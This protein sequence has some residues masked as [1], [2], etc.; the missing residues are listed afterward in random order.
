[1]SLR[2]I[3]MFIATFLAIAATVALPIDVAVT[4][5]HSAT[6]AIITGV[7]L[8]LAVI[9]F[10]ILV[11]LDFRKSGHHLSSLF[12]MA[13]FGWAVL[14][15][16]IASGFANYTAPRDCQY[17][18]KGNAQ[19]TFTTTEICHLLGSSYVQHAIAKGLFV[20]AL[21]LIFLSLVAVPSSER[22]LLRRIDLEACG[23]SVGLSFFFFL[24]YSEL[25]LAFALP[26][27]SAGIAVWTILASYLIARFTLTIR[28]R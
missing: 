1:M 19:G 17:I 6:V 12:V 28:Y 18:V 23:I 21:L 8:G 24:T 27:F 20:T 16:F 9:G 22:E 2:S 4:S 15:T 14:I 13:T 3:R 10:A 25:R 5:R 7:A 11:V 26:V